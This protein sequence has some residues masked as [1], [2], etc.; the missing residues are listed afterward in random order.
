MDR[1]LS[2]AERHDDTQTG[3]CGTTSSHRPSQQKKNES[4]EATP[5]T[6]LDLV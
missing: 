6:I 3:T 1:L 4:I 5:V 2:H